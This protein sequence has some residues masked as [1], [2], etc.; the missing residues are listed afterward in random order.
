M[1]V[2]VNHSISFLTSPLAVSLA[3]VFV[4]CVLVARGRCRVGMWTAA[5]GGIW[6]WLM[7]SALAYGLLGMGLEREFPPMRAE[8]LPTADAIVVLGG[9]MLGNTNTVC[10]AELEMSADR[11]AHA[12]RIYKAGKAPVVIP[13]GKDEVN[14]SKPFLLELGVPESAILVENESKNTEQN[15][16]F[17]AEY[18]KSRH[19]G[20]GVP[21]IIVVT[22]AWHMRRSLLMFE[23][24]A[25]GIEVVP[26]ACDYEATIGSDE[27][28]SLNAIL[29]NA[30]SLLRN[31]CMLKEYI[32][33][34]GYRLLR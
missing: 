32:G 22:S 28:F 30:D 23:K 29:P 19:Q 18:V 7:S 13:S 1:G 8:Q 3:L 2:L 12:A 31:S 10:Y 9:G 11:V 25:D 17:V 27:M 33:Y 16:K 26:G 6:L 34:W 24:Y 14:A 21:K 15:A 4:G 20:S 5:A